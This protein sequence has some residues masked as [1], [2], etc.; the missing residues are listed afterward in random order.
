MH[1][2][3]DTFSESEIYSHQLLRRKRGFPLYDPE[4]QPVPEEYQKCGVAIGDVGRITPEGS[5]D[6]FFNIYLEADHPINNNDVPEN[7]SPLQRYKSRDLYDRPYPPGS[8][9]STSSV[10]RQDAGPSNFPGGLFIFK[11]RAPQGA[12]LA[13]PDGSH[14]QKLRH[15]ESLRTYAAAHAESWFKYVNGPR[16]RGFDGSLYLVTGWEK[17]PTWGIASFHSVDDSLQL[18]FT[19]AAA[20]SRY[21][22]TGNP[23]ETKDHNLSSTDEPTWNQTTFV[24]GL[25][26]SLGRGIW[27]RLFET[28][29]I[30][31]TDAESRLGRGPTSFAS[32]SQGSSL[33]SRVLGFFSK[34]TTTGE[35]DEG[36]NVVLADFPSIS[37]A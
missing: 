6:F 3:D 25:S 34:K 20:D 30:S 21:R 19:P 16:G 7:F 22:W 37:Q 8:H 4:P 24:H 13:L 15:L 18:S 14:L 5:F 28:V 2:V 12:V 32:S 9:V 1:L 35:S 31:E 36:E 11:C 10:Q 26:I 27:T 17:A 29:Q 23:A 33:L